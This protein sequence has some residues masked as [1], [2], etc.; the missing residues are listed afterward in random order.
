MFS[1]L[2]ACTGYWQIRVHETSQE[3]T[4]FV[5]TDGLYEFRVMP[6]GLCNATATFQRLMQQTF[7]GL[8]SFCSVYVDD[9]IVYSSTVEQHLD[10]LK[11]VFNRLRQLG[12]K[13]HPRKCRFAYPKLLYLGHVVSADGS[14][15][16]P[17][18]LRAVQ[19][20]RAPTNVCALREFL[21][22]SGYYR[23]FVPNLPRLPGH[24]TC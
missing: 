9:I 6:F 21:G 19:D 8:D 13:L 5:T 22:L 2:D 23:R 17:E 14:S 18:K 11:Q 16:N 24:C 3:K 20:F 4:A 10:H 15:P 12:L 1:T 7:A